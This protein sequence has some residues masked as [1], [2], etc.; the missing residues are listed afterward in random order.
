MF[1]GPLL[2]ILVS[3]LASEGRVAAL[4]ENSDT[5]QQDRWEQEFKV[6][7]VSDCFISNRREKRG[8]HQID[9]GETLST[10]RTLK[11]NTYHECCS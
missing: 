5:N 4:E 9:K 2:S 1:D 7:G 3:I 6:F 11:D 10:V 8:R